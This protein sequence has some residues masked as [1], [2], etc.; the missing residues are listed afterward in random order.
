[1]SGNINSG[2]P[3]FS[4][5]SSYPF[6]QPERVFFNPYIASEMWVTSFGNGMK[7]GSLLSTGLAGFSDVNELQIF[8]NPTNG[9]VTIMNPDL[10]AGRQEQH[11]RVFNSIG[12]K[13][14]TK[15]LQIGET[16]IDLSFLETG[17][18]FVSYGD[19]KTKIVIR[20]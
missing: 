16:Q 1:M 6:Q 7:I 15:E 20:K 17:I 18:Y 10:P 11:I 12:Q 4:M 14:F 9:M 8:P 3:T 13:V 2:T 19:K 5:V